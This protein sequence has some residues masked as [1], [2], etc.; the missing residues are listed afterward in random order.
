MKGRMAQE[1]AKLLGRY[2]LS[3]VVKNYILYLHE[4]NQI[5][6]VLYKFLPY[7]LGIILKKWTD[8]CLGRKK[9]DKCVRVIYFRGL[10]NRIFFLHCVFLALHN[11]VLSIQNTAQSSTFLWEWCNVQYLLHWPVTLATTFHFIVADTQYIPLCPV[12]VHRILQSPDTF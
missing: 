1:I 2:R 9:Q 7:I 5:P 12:L 3:F 6:G 11:S 8:L 10:E 4:V